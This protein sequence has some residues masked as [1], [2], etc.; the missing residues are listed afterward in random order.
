MDREYILYNLIPFKFIK[1]IFMAQDMVYLWKS[2]M[3]LEKEVYSIV[4]EW[5]VLQMSIRSSELIVMV[6]SFIS[7]LIFCLLVL[8]VER[9]LLTFLIITVSISHCGSISVCFMYLSLLIDLFII[10]KWYSLFLLIPLPWNL[11]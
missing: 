1:S 8:W 9:C 3:S 10:K 5:T 4:V 6:K 11:L 2:S 7:L